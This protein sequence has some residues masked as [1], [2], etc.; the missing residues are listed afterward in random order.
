TTMWDTGSV[1]GGIIAA[2]ELCLVTQKEFDDQITNILKTLNTIEL[3]DGYAPNKAYNTKNGEMVDY[4]NKTSEDGIGVS[5][6]DLARLAAWLNILTQGHPKYTLA[7]RNVMM[8]WN[9]EKLIANGQMY[10]SYR[11]PVSKQTKPV[12]EGRLG[13]EQYAGK[14]FAKLGFNQEISATYH[15]KFKSTVLIYDVPIAYDSR[16]PRELGA[17]NY[18]VTESYALDAMEHGI[19]QGNRALI[20]NI[21]QVQ[22]ERWLK[23]GIVTAVSEDNVDRKPYFVYNTIFTAGIPWNTITDKGINYHQLKSVS[24]KAAMSLALLYPNADYSKLLLNAIESAYHPEKGWYSGVF[25]DGKGY[26]KAITANTNGIILST[27][28]FK[29]HGTLFKECSLCGGDL[30]FA[31]TWAEKFK[32]KNMLA[33]IDN[34]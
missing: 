23:T 1:L 17:Y 16:D 13:Y 4:L 32:P 28:L 11:D 2:R 24:V 22:K 33:L 29:M 15:N 8:R 18:V 31:E 10:G 14:V 9:F 6:L 26:N 7:A 34:K 27:I 19:D 21:F 12:Q 30:T 3:Y 5:V 20:K 25:E